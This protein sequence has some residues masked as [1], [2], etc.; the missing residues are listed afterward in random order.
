MFKN[1]QFKMILIFFLIGIIIIGGFG[2]FFIESLNNMSAQIQTNQMTEAGQVLD[3]IN[4]LKNCISINL[5]L[6]LYLISNKSQLNL[7]FW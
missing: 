3:F 6:I 1:I 2:I 7:L 5:W 4:N